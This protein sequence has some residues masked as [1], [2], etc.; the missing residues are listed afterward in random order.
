[1]FFYLFR[2]SSN[3]I[4]APENSGTGVGGTANCANGLIRSSSGGVVVAQEGSQNWSVNPASELVQDKKTVVVVNGNKSD[5][6]GRSQSSGSSSVNLMRSPSYQ[7]TT[8]AMK[9]DI[10]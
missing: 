2:S 3:S 7:S 5:P 9:N 6:D 8:S 4:S 10:K 1:M